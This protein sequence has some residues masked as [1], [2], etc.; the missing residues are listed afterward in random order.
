MWCTKQ[1]VGLDA[2]EHTTWGDTTGV[3]YS[4]LTDIH[5]QMVIIIPCKDEPL[6][7]IEGVLCGIPAACLILLVSNSNRDESDGFRA[8]VDMLNRFCR[9]SHRRAMA[10][11]QK[12][13]V[14]STALGNAGMPELVGNDGTVRNGKGEGMIL[15]LAV[16]AALLP[17]MRYV[18]F[19]DADCKI[20]GSPHEYCRAYAAG[21]ASSLHSNGD[22]IMV[23]LRWAA[24]PKVRNGRVDF[25][26]R[27]GRS[28]HV[29]NAWMNRVLSLLWERTETNGLP[30]AVND[31]SMPTQA[32][33]H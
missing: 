28:S 12:D 10:I 2:V 23:R 22:H 7:T 6:E 20:P 3:P 13:P 9:Y 1:V 30:T 16:V 19:V 11:H 29:V 27:E 5:R 17:E 26:I 32:S 24:K 31:E 21:F 15:A 14:A 25:T 18:G 4:A 33:I 8:E